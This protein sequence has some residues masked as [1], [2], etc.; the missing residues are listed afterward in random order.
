VSGAARSRRGG[1]RDERRL[2]AEGPRSQHENAHRLREEGKVPR[3]GREIFRKPSNPSICW[4]PAL[5]RA[6]IFDSYACRQGKG[7]LAAVRRVERYARRYGWFLKMDVRMSSASSRDGTQFDAAHE[8][9]GKCQLSPLRKE[10]IVI[11]N[12]LVATPYKDHPLRYL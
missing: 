2:P 12:L 10:T 3:S 6:V 8:V 1:A 7:Q 11:V 4:E 9:T 5:E